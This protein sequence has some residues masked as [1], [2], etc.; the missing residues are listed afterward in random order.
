[1][2]DFVDVWFALYGYSLFSSIFPFTLVSI[3]CIQ[4]LIFHWNPSMPFIIK[5]YNLGT[6]RHKIRFRFPSPF[7]EKVAEGRMR[8]ERGR[9]WGIYSDLN[10]FTGLA[11]AAFIAWY[12]MVAPAIKTDTSIAMINMPAFMCTW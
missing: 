7:L 5:D 2:S 8:V 6:P 1:M 3:P 11:T 9:G 10:D 12:A 4:Y